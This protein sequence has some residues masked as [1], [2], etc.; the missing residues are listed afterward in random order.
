MN[1]RKNDIPEVASLS[2]IMVLG[3]WIRVLGIVAATAFVAA[4]LFSSTWFIKPEYKSIVVMYPVSTSGISKVL[5]NESSGPQQDVLEFGQEEQAEQMLQILNSNVI[6]DRLIK[7]FNLVDH[8]EL[9]SVSEKKM[10]R[11]YRK[12]ESNIKIRRTENMAIK[13]TVFDNDP[14][15]AADIANAIPVLFDSTK[16]AMQRERAMKA[17]R[18]VEAEYRLLVSEIK[19]KEDSLTSIRRKGVYDYETQSEMMNQQLAIEIARGNS[20][21]IKAIEEKLNLLAE[22]GG[23]YV[24]LRD[25]LEHEK[26]RLS[27]IKSLYEQAKVDAY[28]TLPQTFVV[29]TA[30]PAEEKSYPIRWLIVLGTVLS[31]VLLT[32]IAILGLESMKRWRIERMA[33]RRLSI[34]P[35]PAGKA[36]NQ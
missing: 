24:S 26:K 36:I 16:S 31:T 19:S 34:N 23:I 33:E 5:L 9:G 35:V 32:I 28:E 20:R 2:I 12:F 7:E 14:Q 18:I 17:F 3:K 21:G 29:N 15:M 13:V 8:Y 22:Y 10:T 30:Y 1:E 27:S 6:R 4:L 11:L 25:Q